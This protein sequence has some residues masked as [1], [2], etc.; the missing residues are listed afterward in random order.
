MDITKISLNYYIIVFVISILNMVYLP[1][2]VGVLSDFIMICMAIRENLFAK[3]KIRPFFF[4]Y[5]FWIIISYIWMGGNRIV[6]MVNSFG[7]SILPMLFF[8]VGNKI[9]FEEKKQYYTIII[10]FI[11]IML[12]VSLI[13]YITMPD[14]YCEYLINKTWVTNPNR[15]VAKVEARYCLQGFF[16]ATATG[17]FCAI[18][19]LADLKRFLWCNFSK[20]S[21]ALFFLDILFLAMN[22]RKSAILMA[23]FL[24]FVEFINFFKQ[25]KKSSIKPAIL[26]LI[27][28]ILCFILYFIGLYLHI[29]FSSIETMIERFSSANLSDAVSG[30]SGV[31]SRT[32]GNMKNYMY[33][34]GNGF[35]SSGHKA[36]ESLGIFIYDNNWMLIFVET[37]IIGVF[38]FIAAMIE[39]V[40]K[41]IINKKFYALE[42]YIVFLGIMQSATS[43]MLENQ[44][45]TPLFYFALGCCSNWRICT[46]RGELYE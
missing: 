10:S 37:G 9:S 2:K 25:K 19:F 33:F 15:L 17:F 7:Y 36:D 26:L 31:E 41:I 22:S 40:N 42:F 21:V 23:V 20:G 32:L 38:F 29:D 27:T 44:F 45:I 8:I 46:T 13:L 3:L 1:L 14:F 4:F 28:T 12:I 16:G 6:C 24:M 35:G 39:N 5:I 30:R 11:R 43:N 18:L 34:V